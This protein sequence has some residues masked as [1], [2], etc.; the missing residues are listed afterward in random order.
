VRFKCKSGSCR[1]SSGSPHRS[2]R[3][4][5]FLRLYSFFATQPDESYVVADTSGGLEAVVT[6]SGYRFSWM[7]ETHSAGRT[8]EEAIQNV[9]SYVGKNIDGSFIKEI[10]SRAR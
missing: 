5:D 6:S 1:I 3:S 7:P 8:Q 2:K 9:L 4:S 10:A